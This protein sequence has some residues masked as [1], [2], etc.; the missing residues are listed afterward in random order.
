M[1]IFERKALCIDNFVQNWNGY[2]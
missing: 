1:I 2:I